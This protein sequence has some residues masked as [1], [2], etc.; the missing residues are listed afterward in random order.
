MALYKWRGLSYRLYS[1][2]TVLNAC[3][4]VYKNG[5]P[6]ALGHKYTIRMCRLKVYR[7]F[8]CVIKSVFHDG[9]SD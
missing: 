5:K 3:I 1:I 7:V 8:E 2:G 4:C 6:Y 9:L